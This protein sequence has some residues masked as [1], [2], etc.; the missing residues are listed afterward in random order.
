MKYCKEA[1]GAACYYK[2]VPD[3]M[4]AGQ[5]LPVIE[6]NPDREGNPTRNQQFEPNGAY[7]LNTPSRPTAL[8]SIPCARVESEG[9]RLIGA[10]SSSQE[11]NRLDDD[12]QHRQTPDE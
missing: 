6:E 10:T 8:V 11:R 7:A 12:A 3:G 9:D 5:I 2:Q 1:E 4:A